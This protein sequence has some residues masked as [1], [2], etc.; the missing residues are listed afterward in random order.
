MNSRILY[1]LLMHGIQNCFAVAQVTPKTSPAFTDD[2]AIN[3]PFEHSDVRYVI[4]ETATRM[5]F[6]FTMRVVLGTGGHHVSMWK[7]STDFCAADGA[8][9]TKM[10]EVD[11]SNGQ[12]VDTESKVFYAE[13]EDILDVRDVAATLL[14][15]TYFNV[16]TFFREIGSLGHRSGLELLLRDRIAAHKESPNNPIACNSRLMV[17]ILNALQVHVAD[18]ISPR[19]PMDMLDVIFNRIE[20]GYSKHKIAPVEDDIDDITCMLIRIFMDYFKAEG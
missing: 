1:N 20:R 9:E 7:V 16:T 13:C 3:F 5:C 18:R 11:P 12:I 15:G 17:E 14:I 4:D 19:K 10:E 8:V 6:S 2:I